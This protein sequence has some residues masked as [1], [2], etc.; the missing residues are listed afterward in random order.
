MEK[1]VISKECRFVVHVPTKSSD[2]PDVHF[3][4]EVLHFEDG[5]SAPNIRL[6]KDYK[7]PIWVTKPAFRSH[8]DKKEW[9]E[10]DKLLRKDVTQSNMHFA[11]G[12]MLNMNHVRDPRELLGNPYVY[13][14]DVDSTTFIKREYEVKYPDKKTPYSVATLDI[15]TNVLTDEKKI[16]MCTVT[17][18]NKIQTVVEANFIKGISNPIDAIMSKVHKYLGEYVVKNNLQIEILL[19]DDPVEIIKKSFD[20]LHEWKPDILA[21][22]NIDFDIQVILGQLEMAGAD[23]KIYLCDPKVPYDYRICRYKQGPTKKV[24]ASGLVKPLNPSL[25]WHTLELTASFYVLDAMCVYRRLRMAK[26]EKPSYSLDFILS[27]ELGIRKLKFKEVDGFSGLKWHQVMQQEYKAEYIVYNIFDAYSMQE[28][29]AKTK[30]LSYSAPSLANNTPFSK[31]SSQPK[32]IADAFFFF[33]LA[34]KGLVLA[35]TGK[36]PQA[37]I[38]AKETDSDEEEEEETFETLSLKEWICTLPSHMSV[39]GLRLIEEDET[40]ATNIRGYVADLDASAAYPTGILIANISKEN[41]VRELCTIRGIPEEVF[42]LQNLNFVT[43][44]V[45]AIEYTET[46]FGAKSLEDLDKLF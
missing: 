8:R 35:S 39:S 13:G 7:R 28:L 40:I 43:G 22:W 5:T 20:K 24:T 15:E 31:F 1:K 33:L 38:E 46:M 36:T 37:V 9:E 41:T 18:E 27:E 21:I 29:E 34:E 19:A 30:D 14:A 42:R 10:S 23:P 4:K 32:L 11:L 6:I 16:I 3:I 44:K 25:Q 12:R 45:N 2:I 17:F 26:Q